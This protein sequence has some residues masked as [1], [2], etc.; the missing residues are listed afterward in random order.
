MTFLLR[1]SHAKRIRR[2]YHHKIVDHI[3][4]CLRS[5]SACRLFARSARLA[6]YQYHLLACILEPS[7][8]AVNVSLVT[9]PHSADDADLFE[10]QQQVVVTTG[11]RYVSIQI[12]PASFADHIR[13]ANIHVQCPVNRLPVDKQI[14]IYI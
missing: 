2:A 10:T 9:V 4:Q 5:R 12:C 8:A 1:K 6:L 13:N 11:V 14:K 7:S 3:E